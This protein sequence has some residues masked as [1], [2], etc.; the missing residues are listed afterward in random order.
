M[1]REAAVDDDI[2]AFREDELML[3]TQRVGRAPDQVEQT[4]PARFDV[5]CAGG[6]YPPWLVML[7]GHF[8]RLRTALGC[9]TTELRHQMVVKMKQG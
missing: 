4:V 6:K 9:E 2:V 7:V 1:A 3:V 5:R 8:N